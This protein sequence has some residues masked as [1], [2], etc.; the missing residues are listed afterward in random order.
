MKKIFFSLLAIA[1]LASCAKTEAVYTADNSEIQ[2]AP[3]TAMTTK[4]T[5]VIEG[6][7]YPTEE[8]FNVYAY[9][10]NEPAGSSF[11]ADET[12]AGAYLNNVKFINK[13]QFWGGET[14]QY[15]PKNG[16]LRFAAYSPAT[17]NM[18]H[19]L[20][21]DT[22]TGTVNY[23]AS[24][25]QTFDILVA[26]TSKSYTAQTAA[27][28]VSVVFEHALSWLTF[29][30]KST[31]VANNAFTIHN[32]T[33]DGVNIDGTLVAEMNLGTKTWTTENAQDVAVFN[34]SRNATTTAVDFEDVA[35]GLLVLPQQPTT[36]T[37]NFTQNA[38]GS[39][40]AL[41]NQTVTLPLTL[42][43]NEPW[44]AGKHYTYTVIFDLDEILINPDVEEWEEVTVPEIDATA[45]EVSTSEELV[46]A[47][48]AGRSVRLAENI[49]LDAPIIVDPA[50]YATRAG[51]V[52]V[53]VDLNGKTITAESWIDESDNTSNAY[54]F[55]VKPGAKLTINGNGRV[56]TDACTYSMAVWAQGGEVVINGGNY[57]NNGEGSDLI[58]AS[59]GGKV[60]INGGYFEACEKQ[61]GVDGTLEKRS[62]LNLK[63]NGKDGCDIVVYGGQFFGFDPANN[64][65]EN[66]AK[67]FCAVGYA[68]YELEPGIWTVLK[69]DAPVAVE[70]EAALKSALNN[71]GAVVLA[72]DVQIT[73]AVVVPAGKSVVL[74]LNGKNIKNITESD[75]FGEG[76][77]I[78]AYGNLTI[79]GEGTVEASSMAVWA[80]GA[81][82][83]KVTIYGGTY[84]GCAEGFAKGGRSVIYASSDN[85]IDIYGGTFMALAADKT[86]YANKTDGVFAAV[87]VAD[88][89]GMINVYGG[90]FKSQNPAAPGTEP[91][92][93]NANLPNGFVVEGYN[94]V[95][96]NE[97]YT[98]TPA[99]ANV[100]LAADAT[101]A[102]T[103]NVNNAVL[104]GAGH[105]FKATEGTAAMYTASTLRLINVVGDA[106]IKNVVIDGNNAEYTNPTDTYGI[107]GIFA[108]QAGTV[109]I[110]NVTIK[111]VT[112]TIND[113]AAV[114]TL[115]VT[116]S[117]LE[118]WTSYN[119]G[120]VASFNNV[121]FTCGTQKTFR[122]HG[123]TVLK[124]CAF[125]EGFQI[126]LD[127]LQHEIVF[128]GCT[129]AGRA[130]TAADLQNA[131]GKNVTI[132]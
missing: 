98:V 37:I 110:D 26:P 114:K 76:E 53:V 102:A 52:D 95:E 50:A 65:S 34:G 38:V 28:K 104:D 103:Y 88:N 93:W 118:G 72:K 20:A 107:R 68:S 61:A 19:V 36:V 56:E 22:Y 58:Y 25:A 44:E 16:S 111:N 74:D 129:Y 7:E 77:A 84:K 132:K 11:E 89:K 1:A 33:V 90:S 126:N 18:Q 80:R 43:E 127:K 69:A 109:N 49:Q 71:G 82:D 81:N 9:W 113:D 14:T 128:E 31:D 35:K 67:N 13:G 115:N 51:V 105:T 59:A 57:Y 47:V 48:A 122:P 32:V 120:T 4:V 24:T 96:S 21:T 55:W 99:T 86:S 97:W 83:A 5:G 3:V 70:N 64:K 112:Y 12:G 17:I 41:A 94:V 85:T 92:A 78:I 100:V 75:V 29:Q 40:P 119:P 116:N 63:G 106:T 15:W 73:S 2:I 123:A 30:I 101:V 130:L 108:T 79:K 42:V 124:N 87:N 6:T 91:A 60:T 54:A 10:A 27:E 131:T 23:T 121:K 66:P 117:T 45:T 62:A 46:E 125:A 8:N 39:A